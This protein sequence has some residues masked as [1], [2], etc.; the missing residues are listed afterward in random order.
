M[1]KLAIV[2]QLPS[3]PH[4]IVLPGR[5]F[6]YEHDVG[7]LLYL[8]ANLAG[9][10]ALLHVVQRFDHP[11]LHGKILGVHFL[12]DVESQ[13]V[14]RVDLVP[15]VVLIL[16]PDI[17]LDARTYILMLVHVVKNAGQ[18]ELRC[19]DDGLVDEEVDG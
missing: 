18:I 11:F 16:I 12:G 5:L 10:F 19:S 2:E 8:V 13:R 1:N 7:H 17:V 3:L 6:Q 9:G 15:A 4:D 14:S